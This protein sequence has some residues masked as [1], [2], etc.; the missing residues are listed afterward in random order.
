MGRN[1]TL[2]DVVPLEWGVGKSFNFGNNIFKQVTIG[3]VGYAQW[4]VTNNQ[5]DVTPTTAI[6]ASV[7]H[8]LEHTS[9]RVYSAGPAINLLTKYGLF[10]LRYYEEFDANATPSGRQLMFSI[11]L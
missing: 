10:S 5:I 4:Q 11:T 6:G 9:S 8:T 2:G 7:L 3:P 1:Y